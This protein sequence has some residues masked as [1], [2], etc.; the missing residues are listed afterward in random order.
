MKLHLLGD[1]SYYGADYTMDIYKPTFA[2]QLTVLEL[3][4]IS[5]GRENQEMNNEESH[6]PKSYPVNRFGIG[7]LLP[8]K[9]L[10]DINQD[11]SLEINYANSD[12]LDNSV[13]SYSS[14]LFD[15]ESIEFGI[16]LGM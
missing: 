12:W 13:K 14:R 2:I 5:F 3:I 4:Q 6:Y 7:I 8:L 9:E 11:V 1:I 16:H 15:D 10:I